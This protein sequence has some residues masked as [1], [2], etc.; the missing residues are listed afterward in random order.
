MD[1][2]WKWIRDVFQIQQKHSRGLLWCFDP[3]PTKPVGMGVL[4]L[5]HAPV[6]WAGPGYN[7]LQ[8]ATRT[9][10]P[11]TCTRTFAHVCQFYI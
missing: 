9:I 5:Q 2:A 1:P 3:I 6:H 4:A 10:T 8:Y 11:F 7:H